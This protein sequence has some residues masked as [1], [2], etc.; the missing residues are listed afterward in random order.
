[1]ATNKEAIKNLQPAWWL[2]KFGGD[3]SKSV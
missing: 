1:M 2:K 3:V